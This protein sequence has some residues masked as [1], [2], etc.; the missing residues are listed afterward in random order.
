MTSS[1]SNSKETIFGYLKPI[2]YLFIAILVIL[3]A[4]ILVVYFYQDKQIM[5]EIHKNNILFLRGD[6]AQKQIIAHK[7][8]YFYESD[9]DLMMVG[10]SSGFA[11]IQPL[12]VNKQ[13]ENHKLINAS[14]CADSGWDGYLALT[15][16]HLRNNKNIKYLIIYTYPSALP[17][18]ESKRINSNLARQLSRTYSSFWHF[19]YQFPSLYLKSRIIN[20]FYHPDNQVVETKMNHFIEEFTDG[21]ED[22]YGN[23]LANNLG[24]IPYKKNDMNPSGA[25][26]FE[27]IKQP[28]GSQKYFDNY[29]QKTKKLADSYGVKLVI[30]FA[31]VPCKL[32]P[33]FDQAVV[34]IEQFKKGNPDVL[35]LF[36]YENLRSKDDFMDNVHLTPKGSTSYS[37]EFGKELKKVLEKE[38]IQIR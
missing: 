27:T 20:T 22:K 1:I 33:N 12:I 7:N 29:L 19:F 2:K 28:T 16:H 4:E 3:V 24:W 35:F 10:D 26:L 13:L 34:E 36:G 9:A 30:V 32:L 31:P 5:R 8:Y 18:F 11:N 14:C 6:G 37:E 17:F 25:C 15:E 21:H 38:D 23:F